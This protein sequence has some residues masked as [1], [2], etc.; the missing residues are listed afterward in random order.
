MKESI[1]LS[2]FIS[3]Y[4]EN[5]QSALESEGIEYKLRKTTPSTT[6]RINRG[7]LLAALD[8]LVRNS[9]YWLRRGQKVFAKIARPPTIHVAIKSNGFVIWDTGQGV[10]S[11]Y[12]DNLFEIFVSAKPAADRGQG[13][14]SS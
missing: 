8:N 2:S 14:D 11:A 1:E 6:V 12:E 10:D 13:S 5:R 4:F 3:E 7:R 9:V